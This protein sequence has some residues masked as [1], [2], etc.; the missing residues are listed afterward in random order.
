MQRAMRAFHLDAEGHWVAELSCGHRQHVRH[1]PPFTLRPWVLTEAGR[2][3]RIGQSLDVMRNALVQDE[4]MAR[5]EVDQFP[6]W[7]MKDVHAEVSLERLYRDPP[8]RL[9]LPDP[10]TSSQDRQDEPE[11]LVLDEGLCVA[12]NSRGLLVPQT[13]YFAIEIEAQRRRIH[14]LDGA[15]RRPFCWLTRHRSSSVVCLDHDDATRLA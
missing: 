8:A 4:E 14:G 15:F 11:I 3:E 2:S 6:F 9:V 7:R 13:S 1:Q 10:S 5:G 12:A